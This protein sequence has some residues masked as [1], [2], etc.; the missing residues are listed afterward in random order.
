MKI[1]II[2]KEISSE[3]IMG[4]DTV[5]TVFCEIPEINKNTKVTIYHTCSID[6][7]EKILN[8]I[9]SN[10]GNV[11]TIEVNNLNDLT[12]TGIYY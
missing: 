4:F 2:P 11:I 6:K 10:K 5:Y 8:Y 9:N 3:T 7:L 12:L 1:K